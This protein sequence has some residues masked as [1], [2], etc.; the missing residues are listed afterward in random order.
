MYGLGKTASGY[1]Q[2]RSIYFAGQLGFWQGRGTLLLPTRP[3]CDASEG[4]DVSQYVSAAQPQGR[5]ILPEGFHKTK[6]LRCSVKSLQR[7]PVG[8]LLLGSADI[9]R[10][11]GTPWYTILKSPSV[12]TNWHVMACQSF[13]SGCS[14]GSSKYASQGD[15][16]F[17]PLSC[18]PL[19]TSLAAFQPATL[20]L[21]C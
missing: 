7:F 21:R 10:L 18:L 2:P 15:T 4:S 1:G 14:A 19:I 11:Y 5:V 9:N 16:G 3:R 8:L 20:K 17:P 12:R 13:L 6:I